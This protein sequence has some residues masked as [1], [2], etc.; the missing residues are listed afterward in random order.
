MWKDKILEAKAAK[1]ISTKVIAEKTK[2]SEKTVARILKGETL[3]PSVDTVLDIGA[4]VGLSE[5][6][7]FSETNL[8]VANDDLVRLQTEIA[9]LMDKCVRL[10]DENDRLRTSLSHKEEILLHKD[11][12]I[13]L[14]RALQKREGI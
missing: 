12:I 2:L 11:E 3:F 14:Y 9:S 13:S 1:G 5:R 10:E 7:L 4:A 8:V 6:E